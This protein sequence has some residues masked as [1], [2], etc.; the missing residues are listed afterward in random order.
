V[1]VGKRSAGRPVLGVAWRCSGRK[2]STDLFGAG[3]GGAPAS[4]FFL[5]TLA[6]E[7][8]LHPRWLWL[9]GRNPKLRVPERAMTAA[10]SFP[11]CRHR[12]G[13]LTFSDGRVSSVVDVAVDVGAAAPSG[14]LASRGGGLEDHVR[15]LFHGA[16]KLLAWIGWQSCVACA[17]RLSA[18]STPLRGGGVT[19]RPGR[20]PRMSVRRPWSMSS[21][22]CA[23][24]AAGGWVVRRCGSSAS[25]GTSGWRSRKVVCELRGL[26]SC[27]R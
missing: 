7:L 9:S 10:T 24:W 11:S 12:L 23:A 14:G 3:S 26:V 2:P 18:R 4:F 21:F 8:R 15:Q 25:G 27:G 22:P 6:V 1:A 19:F 5:E 20:R 13:E 16:K 17:A